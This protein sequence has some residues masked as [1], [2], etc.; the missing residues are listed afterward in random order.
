MAPYD[1]AGNIRQALHRLLRAT[2]RLPHLGVGVGEKKG[3]LFVCLFSF[4]PPENSL[5]APTGYAEY[6]GGAG[7]W[8][9][10]G[11]KL[12]KRR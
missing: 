3:L 8:Y 1:V 9:R 12:V 10:T 5:Q 2:L 6:R 11:F 7:A 4:A